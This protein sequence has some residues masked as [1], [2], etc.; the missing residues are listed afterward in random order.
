[1]FWE[2]TEHLKTSRNDV[3]ILSFQIVIYMLL[4][5]LLS[6][7]ADHKLQKWFIVHFSLFIL[8][9]K[10]TVCDNQEKSKL[11]DVKGITRTINI[12]P[13]GQNI[14]QSINTVCKCTFTCESIA[15]KLHL[16]I[17]IKQCWYVLLEFWI[18][19]TPHLTLLIF[20]GLLLI[21][22]SL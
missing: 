10:T 3:L 21:T 9:A 1:M 5:F 7:L 14:E 12:Q 15:R 19:Y 16:Y 8:S 22:P 13:A 11:L 18:P 6:F 4:L 17:L 2:I 20:I